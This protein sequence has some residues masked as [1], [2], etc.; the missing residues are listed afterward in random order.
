MCAVYR[1]SRK[2]SVCAHL[3]ILHISKLV[4]IRVYDNDK[5]VYHNV[6]HHIVLQE[7]PIS[8]LS[9]IICVAIAEEQRPQ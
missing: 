3:S 8:I 9:R 7:T 1:K 6:T 4:H 5:L 2:D